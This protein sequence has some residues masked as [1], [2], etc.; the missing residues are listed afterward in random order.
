MIN[1]IHEKEKEGDVQM[2]QELDIAKYQKA[3]NTATMKSAT[4]NKYSGVAGFYEHDP[5]SA[6]QSNRRSMLMRQRSSKPWL[7]M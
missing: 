6:A 2:T 1:E 3:L 7:S 4:M 5:K